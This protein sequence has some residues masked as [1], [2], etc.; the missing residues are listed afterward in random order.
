MLAIQ[1]LL[2]PLTTI[3][4]ALFFGAC[5]M[6]GSMWVHLKYRSGQ[7]Q[8]RRLRPQR[9]QLLHL[10]LHRPQRRRLPLHLHRSQRQLRPLPRLR[11]LRQ[12]RRQLRALPLHRFR[13]RHPHPARQRRRRRRLGLRRRPQLHLHQDLR[14]RRGTHHRPGRA[15][16]PHRT[17]R[18]A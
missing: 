15:R 6:I 9:R 13:R 2:R 5:A 4:A 17:R 16:L 18:L 11:P 3:S 7:R 1:T 10:L 12:L 14:S 8:V